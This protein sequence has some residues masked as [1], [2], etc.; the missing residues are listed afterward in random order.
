MRQNHDTRVDAYIAKA[1]PFAQ[2]ILTH[3]RELMHKASPEVGETMKWGM[4]F[5]M[6]HGVIL[7]NMAG[8]KQHCSLG[9][10]GPQISAVLKNDGSKADS[11]MGAF[12]RI[13]GLK[14]LP[15]DKVL[16]GYLQQAAGFVLTG[17]RTTS[18]TRPASKKVKPAPE[19]PE[20]LAA[21]LKK[22]KAAAKVFA[23]FS[24][25][26]QREYTEW[27]VEAK[28]AETKDKRVA[29]A[30]EWMAEGRQRNWKYQNC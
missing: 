11:G 16:L 4:P 20:E 26:C 23:A 14:D 1:Q 7:G 2:E 3:I 12:G 22:N 19:V 8:F 15:A 28:R 25:S 13:T 18:I 6:L 24:P 5:F 30:V 27:I 9:L 10:W 17:E 29:Q 21:A